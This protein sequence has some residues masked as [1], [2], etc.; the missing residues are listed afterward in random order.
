MCGLT[1]SIWSLATLT[2]PKC[3]FQEKLC[4]SFFSLWV[5]F[6]HDY[7]AWVMK[8]FTKK[9]VFYLA[10]RMGS[11]GEKETKWNVFVLNFI[12]LHVKAFPLSAEHF[13]SRSLQWKKLI[14]ISRDFSWKGLL[15][16]LHTETRRSLS[17]HHRHVRKRRRGWLLINVACAM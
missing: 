16:C 10:S 2:C 7:L 5:V 4:W 6:I 9:S 8:N 1:V 12:W 17:T 13:I 11:E 15:N 3:L 14:L